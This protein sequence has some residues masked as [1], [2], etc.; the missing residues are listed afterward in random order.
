MGLK[1]DVRRFSAAGQSDEDCDLAEKMITKL[2]QVDSEECQTHMKQQLRELQALNGTLR[3]DDFC[4]ICGIPL[5]PASACLT[6]TL[7]QCSEQT[8]ISVLRKN[9][10]FLGRLCGQNLWVSTG[11]SVGTAVVSVSDWIVCTH[12]AGVG[13]PLWLQASQ[14]IGS[15][16][17]RIERR[18]SGQRTRSSESRH[19]QSSRK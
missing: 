14:A 11:A 19:L 3:D 10:A 18:G 12:S 13:C 2:L 16:N 4:H 9:Y 8:L 7:R 17:A 6:P 1:T 15:G 5:A